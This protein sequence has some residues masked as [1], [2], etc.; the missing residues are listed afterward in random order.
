MKDNVWPRV[1]NP[2]LHRACIAHIGERNLR[3]GQIT[4]NAIEIELGAIDQRQLRGLM[5]GD[6]ARE[7]ATNRT[8]TARDQHALTFDHAVDARPIDG[9]QSAAEQ[10]IQAHAP[11]RAIFD[12]HQLHARVRSAFQNCA[13]SRAVRRRFGEDQHLRIE[14][15]DVDRLPDGSARQEL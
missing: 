10:I 3:I 14:R 13:C 9:A 4:V 15:C 6:A 7:L 2:T 11:Q 8:A 5:H 1:G 12:Q